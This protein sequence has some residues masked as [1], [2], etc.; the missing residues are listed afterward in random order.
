MNIKLCCNILSIYRHKLFVLEQKVQLLTTNVCVR[1]ALYE[2][3]TVLSPIP[4]E[5]EI[6]TATS[7]S[8]F[9]QILYLQFHNPNF[10]HVCKLRMFT[11]YEV[12]PAGR[13][14]KHFHESL[15]FH[16]ARLNQTPASPQNGQKASNYV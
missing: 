9:M 13:K 7:L 3:I 16:M 1:V 11:T 12:S 2:K 10:Q 5:F 8:H 6:I 4:V 15:L 14:Q